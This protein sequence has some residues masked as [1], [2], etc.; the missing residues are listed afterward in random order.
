M[1]AFSAKL[2]ERS[3]R[4]TCAEIESFW[5]EWNI[6]TEEQQQE[7]RAAAANSSREL[8]QDSNDPRSTALSKTGRFGLLGIWPAQTAMFSPDIAQLLGVLDGG[9]GCEPPIIL[10]THGGIIWLVHDYLEA[11]ANPDTPDSQGMTA[12][13]HACCDPNGYD[14]A[15]LLCV[16]GGGGSVAKT[17]RRG[18]TAEVFT[19][20]HVNPAKAES[21]LRLLDLSGRLRHEQLLAFGASLH[22]R[23]G[24]DSWVTEHFDI[25]ILEKVA[26]EVLVAWRNQSLKRRGEIFAQLSGPGIFA[27]DAGVVQVPSRG[28][29]CDGSPRLDPTDC[30]AASP[31]TEVPPA[32]PTQPA[33]PVIPSRR[34]TRYTPREGVKM[35]TCHVAKLNHRQL[36]DSLWV[37][38]PEVIIGARKPPMFPLVY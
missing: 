15:S 10:A 37:T 27:R 17:N 32:P 21:L 34:D 11:G 20:R 19:R 30:F 5:Q 38:G 31:T 18:E 28:V 25:V 33:R 13:M 22:L 14:I 16:A 24:A 8:F 1:H 2:P 4:S 26:T 3:C 36:R 9:E 29:T 35:L 7:L 12:L 23:L 6:L